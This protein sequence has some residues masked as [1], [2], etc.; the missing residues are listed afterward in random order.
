MH[1]LEH[2]L[3][4]LNEIGQT[5]AVLQELSK[6]EYA[7][8]IIDRKGFLVQL[9]ENEFVLDIFTSEEKAQVCIAHLQERGGK[10]K[11]CKPKSYAFIQTYKAMAANIKPAVAVN[12]FSPEEW[13]ASFDEVQKY[14]E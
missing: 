9:G 14:M 2:A 3:L 4:K 10:F 13:F 7:W 5:G 1:D 12:R 8:M 6:A 11:G